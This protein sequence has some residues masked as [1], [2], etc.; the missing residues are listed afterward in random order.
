MSR[1]ARSLLLLTALLC[2]AGAGAQPAP[3]GVD[4]C[5]VPGEPCAERIMAAID[6][7]RREVRVQ[8]YG[9]TS[10]PVIAAFTNS[11]TAWL[12]RVSD[13]G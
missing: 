6:A 2:P 7:A 8:A 11:P 9:F 10:F 12:R 3:A 5:F 4:V 1:C 13:L